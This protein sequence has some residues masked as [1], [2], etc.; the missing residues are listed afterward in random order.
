MAALFMPVI[1]LVTGI[2]LPHGESDSESKFAAMQQALSSWP[3]RI[4]VL[5]VV[6]LSFIHCAHRI[7]HTLMD[8]GFR[9]M[10]TLLAVLCYGGAFAGSVVAAVVLYQM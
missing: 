7:R 1:I 2:I 9:P 4:V 3:A 10:G 6:F 5:G 8:F